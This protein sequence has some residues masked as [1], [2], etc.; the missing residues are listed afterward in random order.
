MRGRPERLPNAVK[1]LK[2]SDVGVIGG[3]VGLPPEQLDVS[4]ETVDDHG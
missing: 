4:S 2:L 1:V 3:E